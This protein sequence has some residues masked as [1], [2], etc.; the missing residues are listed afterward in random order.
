MVVECVDVGWSRESRHAG[1][2]CDGLCRAYV[3][4]VLNGGLRLPNAGSCMRWVYNGI[5]D[6]TESASLPL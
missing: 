3:V 1:Q 5:R 2:A 4:V 6:F